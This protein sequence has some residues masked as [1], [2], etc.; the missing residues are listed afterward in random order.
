[1][2]DVDY[3]INVLGY[4]LRTHGDVRIGSLT[5]DEI[6]MAYKHAN[7]LKRRQHLRVV[8]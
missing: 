1:M 8:R 6:D 5:L 2:S 3:M 4:L 7:A